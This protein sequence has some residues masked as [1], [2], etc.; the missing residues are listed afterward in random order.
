M[1]GIELGLAPIATFVNTVMNLRVSYKAADFLTS[2]N[3]NQFFKKGS[4][5]PCGLVD[6]YQ[7]FGRALCLSY[8][9]VKKQSPSNRWF[10]SRKPHGVTRQQT[11]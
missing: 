7:H 1:L 10:V 11:I 8:P 4:V 9:E 5:T 2:I 6:I 3:N